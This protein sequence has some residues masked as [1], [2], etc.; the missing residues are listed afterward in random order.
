MPLE[1]LQMH[2]FL[3][4]CVHSSQKSCSS[5]TERCCHANPLQ[6]LLQ[7]MV[8]VDPIG[9]CFQFMCTHGLASYNSTMQTCSIQRSF[10]ISTINAKPTSSF[11]Q[12]K[13]SN[14][15]ICLAFY[16][17]RSRAFSWMNSRTWRSLGRSRGTSLDH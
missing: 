15:W 8:I 12:Q 16:R 2:T 1:L 11:K 7:A 13:W 5:T 3:F 14:L 10:D 6:L 4:R 9:R 17:E